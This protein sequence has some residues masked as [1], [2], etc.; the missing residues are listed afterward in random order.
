MAISPFNGNS[1]KAKGGRPPAAGLDKRHTA[2]VRRIVPFGVTITSMEIG[3]SPLITS[4]LTQVFKG[5]VAEGS[6]GAAKAVLIQPRRAAHRTAG[7]RSFVKD[8]SLARRHGAIPSQVATPDKRPGRPFQKEPIS[9]PGAVR[10]EKRTPR[11][12]SKGGEQTSSALRCP[13][14]WAEAPSMA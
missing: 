7:W 6:A 14:H 4:P 9:E 8:L 10:A 3:G 5:P 1:I 2:A 11:V 13:L 12:T